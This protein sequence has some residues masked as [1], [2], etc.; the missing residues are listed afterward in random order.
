[1]QAVTVTHFKCCVPRSRT[2]FHQ[3]FTD[4]IILLFDDAHPQVVHILK[5]QANAM[6]IHLTYSPELSKS[7][8]HVCGSLKKALQGYTFT[9]DGY[10]QKVVLQQHKEFCVDRECTDTE[11]STTGAHV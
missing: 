8:L 11:L 6:L 7:N 10:V 4:S 1:M 5:K 9:L 2:N 3:N